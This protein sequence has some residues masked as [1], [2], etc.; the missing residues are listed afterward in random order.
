MGK[1]SHTNY[2]KCVIIYPIIHSTKNISNMPRSHASLVIRSR[3]VALFWGKLLCILRCLL[4]N[5]PDWQEFYTTVGRAKYQLWNPK[6]FSCFCLMR[7]PVNL[8][9]SLAEVG[10]FYNRYFV[11]PGKPAKFGNYINFQQRSKSWFS[12]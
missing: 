5:L 1:L 6:V 2:T 10:M 9:W 8:V 7:F 11:F 4:T 12:A 3:T